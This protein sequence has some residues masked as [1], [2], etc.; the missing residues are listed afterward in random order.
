MDNYELTY[1]VIKT[2]VENGIRYIQDNPKRGVRNLLD[3]GEYFARGRFQKD[4]FELAHGI[5]KNEDSYYYDIIESLIKNT[6]HK[7]IADFGINIGF[8]SMTYGAN[9]IREN[10][11]KFGYNIPWVIVFDFEKSNDDHIS[12]H[13]ADRLIQEGKKTGIYSYMIM[14][15]KNIEMFDEMYAAIEKN[16]DCAIVI[17]IDPCIIDEET[18]KKLS[19]LS[20]TCINVIIEDDCTLAVEK[21]NILKKYKCFYGGYMYYN[22]NNAS[23]IMNGVVSNKLM[24]ASMN[25]AVLVKDQECS[26]ETSIKVYE[27]IYN[28]RTRTNHPVCLMDFYGD[29][30]RIDSIISEESFFLSIDSSGQATASSLYGAKTYLNITESSLADVLKNIQIINH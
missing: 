16:R 25:F 9:I 12:V 22:D 4:F 6:K 29:I 26:D 7:S 27:Y 21:T 11:K 19:N 20:N 30:A 14:L 24:S 28:S 23:D 1:A 13:E 8:N 3:L 2:A 10:E 18:A 5:L 15:G 17:F